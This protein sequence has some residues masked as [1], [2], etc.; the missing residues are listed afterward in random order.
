MVARYLTKPNYEESELF[1][2][3]T[4]RTS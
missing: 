1:N 2:I 3:C 4:E